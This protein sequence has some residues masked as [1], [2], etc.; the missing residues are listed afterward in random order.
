MQSIGQTD[1]IVI[2]FLGHVV[3]LMTYKN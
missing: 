3:G 2:S 1:L